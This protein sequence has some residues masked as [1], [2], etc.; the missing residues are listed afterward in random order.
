MASP[1]DPAASPR[2]PVAWLPVSSAV[3]AAV[4]ALAATANSYGYHRDELYFLMLKPAWGYVDQPPLT[5]LLARAAHDLFGQTVWGLRVPAILAFAATVLLVALTTRELGGGRGAQALSAWAVAFAAVPVASGHLLVTT[6]LDLP[7]WAAVLLCATRALLRDQPRW[8]LAAG[9]LVGLAMYNKL[10][11]AMLLVGLAVGLLA[12]G[13]RSVPRSRWLWGGVALAMVLGAPNLIYQVTHDFPQL[14][15]GA[16]LAENNAD[17]VRAQ[18]VPFQLLLVGPPL[19]AIWIAGFVALWRRPAWRPVRAVAV[20]Y[21]VVVVL[22]FVGGA[23]VYYAMGVM[24]YLLAAGAVVTADWAAR[25]RVAVR[26][27][28]VVAA[29]ALNVAA[30][31]LIS[32]PFIPVTRVGDTFV[33]ELNQ[34]TGDQVG[35]PAYVA[36]IA[37][38]HRALPAPDQA[39]A[40]VVT[41]NYGEA[42]AVAR[43]GPALGLPAVYSG[44]NELYHYGPPPADRTVAV[45]VGQRLPFLQT[46]F[47]AC[48]SAGVLDNGVAVD[49]EEQDVP[50]WVCRDPVGGWSAVWPRLQHYD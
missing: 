26:R 5:P 3:A 41:G 47:A 22:T 25:G 38:V 21:L 17:E 27:G 12:V 11:I 44:Q 42:G 31:C 6:T 36:E 40:V 18:T 34:V 10:L 24:V 39:R 19:A 1:S 13:P 9:A 45:V 37:R 14:E 35:W 20:A 48:V 7:L 23:Q 8:W 4:A 50:V 28:L 30:T 2:P 46:R 15:M 33:P 29:V 32:L 43:F 16:A 49:N